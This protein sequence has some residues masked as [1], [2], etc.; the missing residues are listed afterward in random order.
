MLH[1]L[2]HP[3]SPMQCILLFVEVLLALVFLLFGC[4]LKSAFCMN[5][6]TSC[7]VVHYFVQ[8]KQDLDQVK[9]MAGQA[10]KQL[11]NLAGKFLSDLSR[12]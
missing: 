9:E 12:Y 10:A 1:L 5:A 6:H 4:M 11:S 7:C 8:A 2:L 3:V